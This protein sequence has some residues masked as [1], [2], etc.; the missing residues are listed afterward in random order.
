M[1]YPLIEKQTEV[2]DYLRR[3]V[4]MYHQSNL[5]FRDIQY[6]IQQLLGEHGDHVG[7]A[8]AEGRAVEFC[9]ALER[10]GILVPIDS[11]TWTL[12]YPSFKTPER[13]KAPEP[14]KPAPKPA[15]GAPPPVKP[16]KPGTP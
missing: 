7:Y 9:A 8:E 15:A 14:P 1:S 6:G 2:L 5:F 13:K 11:Q 10:Q 12:N 4:P 16:D 3:R